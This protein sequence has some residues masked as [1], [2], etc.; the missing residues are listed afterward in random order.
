[1]FLLGMSLDQ[2]VCLYEPVRN[3]SLPAT[4][5]DIFPSGPAAEGKPKL[6]VP[7]E[8]WRLVDALWQLGMKEK[9]LFAV[10][11]D[12]AEVDCVSAHLSK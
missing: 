9:D 10:S 7:K 1:M 8:L 4:P 11:V 12:E 3:Y 6:S 2:L 5:E